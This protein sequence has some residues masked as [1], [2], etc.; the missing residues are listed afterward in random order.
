MRHIAALGAVF[1]F[2]W[3]VAASG[4]EP[5]FLQA[6]VRFDRAALAR[7]A[8][9]RLAVVLD[10]EEGYHINANPASAGLEP[11]VVEPENHPAITWGEVKYPPGQAYTP[12]WAAGESLSV[13]AGRAVVVLAGTVAADAPLGETT[14]RVTLRYQG[15]SE[16]A[17]FRPDMR[18]LE[19]QIEIREAGAAAVPANADLFAAPKL[20]SAETVGEE[21][22]LSA[23]LEKSFFLYLGALALL[24]LGLNLTPCVFPLIPVTMSIFAQQGEGRARQVLPLAVLYV[25]GLAATFTVV[26]VVAALAGQSIGMV[27]QQPVGV[28][29][30]VGVLAILMASTFGAFEIR[31]PSGMM[32]KLGARRGYLG[33]I[34]MGIVMGAIAAPCVGPF[35]LALIALVAKTGSVPLGAVSFFATGIG[36]GLPYVFLGTFTGLV[37]RFPRSGG[38]LVW[39]KR[40]LGLSLAGLILWFVNPYIDGAFFRPLALGVFLFA[41]VYLGLVEGWSRRPFSRRFWTV[42]IAAA[43]LIL[44]AGGAYGYVTA[45]RPEVQWEPWTPAALEQAKAEGRPVLLYFGAE[46]C[47]PCKVWRYGNFRNPRVVELSE[48]F[49]RVKV[50]LTHLEEGPMKDFARRFN[51]VNPPGVFVIGRDGRTMASF[52]DPPS[53][54]Q[55]LGAA[56]NAATGG[57]EAGG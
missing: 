11:T 25:L 19:A 6:S 47:F 41:A 51:S 8:A 34:F 57:Q 15:C 22:R 28:V 23:A 40:L 4:A 14:V 53:A 31:L 13:Y 32:G 30:L 3:A 45:D 21:D 46:W 37:N 17:C 27:L 54:E 12:T 7:G 33:A 1:L 9:F 26:G 44:A 35:L 49:K 55:F 16:S 52:R 43:V 50:D 42:R 5:G 20:V 18:T 38:W 29:V 48:E 56:R 2:A 10:I 24:G 36:L 39:T